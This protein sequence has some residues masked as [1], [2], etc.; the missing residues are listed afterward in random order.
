LIFLFDVVFNPA[1]FVLFIEPLMRQKD[2]SAEMRQT[3][4]AEE[5]LM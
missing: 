3:L 5:S 4:E 1:Q 2:A